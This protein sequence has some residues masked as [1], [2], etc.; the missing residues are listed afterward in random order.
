MV[1]GAERCHMI[2]LT[3]TNTDPVTSVF[4]EFDL[5]ADTMNELLEKMKAL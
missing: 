3:D 5:Y 2:F 1:C 4:G